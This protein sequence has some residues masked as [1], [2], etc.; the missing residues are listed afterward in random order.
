MEDL[1]ASGRLDF[2][3]MGDWLF[4]DGAFGLELTRERNLDFLAGFLGVEVLSLFIL[5]YVPVL[6]NRQKNAVVVTEVLWG[7]RFFLLPWTAVVLSLLF[8]PSFLLANL[9]KKLIAGIIFFE[10]G[11]LHQ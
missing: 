7:G 11:L 10:A 9:L 6:A 3:E 8:F 4:P 1:W 2:D 5:E